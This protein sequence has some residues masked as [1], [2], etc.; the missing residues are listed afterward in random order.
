MSQT[1]SRQPSASD[2]SSRAE[3]E[4]RPKRRRRGCLVALAVVVLVPLLA[5]L[6][7]WLFSRFAVDAALQRVKAAVM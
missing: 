2:P 1:S 3:S 7:Y 4:A 5:C 6:G